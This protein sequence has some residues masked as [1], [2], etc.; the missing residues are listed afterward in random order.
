MKTT[1]TL[2]AEQR[3]HLKTIKES[4]IENLEDII[5]DNDEFESLFYDVNEFDE[6]KFKAILIHLGLD[7]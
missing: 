3:E 1:Y 2:S 6:E 5:H 7:Y 4:L